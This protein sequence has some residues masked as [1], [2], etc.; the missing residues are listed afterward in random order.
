[1]GFMPSFPIVGGGTGFGGTEIKSFFSMIKQFWSGPNESS[2][3]GFINDLNKIFNSLGADIDEMSK[4]VT[5]DWNATVLGTWV[6]NFFHNITYPIG[7][8]LLALFFMIGYTKRAAMFK[9]NTPENIIKVLLQLMFAKMIMENSLEILNF[10][11]AAV[12]GL[13]DKVATYT[14]N[15]A[16]LIDFIDMKEEWMKMSYWEFL[17]MSGRLWPLQVGMFISKMLIG[18]IC[19]GRVIEVYLFTVASPI[20]LATIASEEYSSI[21]K[22]F[23][24]HYIS[25][26]LQGFLIIVILKF[27]PL[28]VA[29]VV[30]SNMKIDVWGVIGLNIVLVMLLF[31]SGNIAT[32]LTGG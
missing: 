12:S 29:T 14:S 18:V 20:P 28:L 6:N 13:V 19:Y 32:K 21:G 8:S 30:A 5:M 23:F 25:V 1:M 7:L 22:R 3:T 26:C 24:Q 4:I 31:R 17:K 10:I 2:V 27:F 15:V 9:L 16:N 11:F